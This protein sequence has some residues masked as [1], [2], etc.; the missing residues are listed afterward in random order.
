MKDDIFYEP[1]GEANYQRTV[2]ALEREIAR[3]K[4]ELLPTTPASPIE[5]D[6]QHRIWL[7]LDRVSQYL[8]KIRDNAVDIVHIG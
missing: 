7:E 6:K 3:L 2:T 5:Y 4:A 8:A 1:V